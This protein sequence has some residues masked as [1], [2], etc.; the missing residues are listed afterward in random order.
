MSAAYVVLAHKHP[1]QVARLATRLAPAPVFLHVDAAVDPAAFAAVAPGNVVL[2]P[3]HRSGWASWGIVAAILGGMAAAA[4]APGWTHLMVLSGQDYPLCPSAAT[5]AFLARHQDRSFVAR[6]PLPSRLWGR[7][8]GMHRVRYRHWALRG[9][10]AFLP[11][12]RSMPARIAPWGGS[13]YVC[14]ARRAVED[15]LELIERRPDV[16]RFYRRTWIPDEMFLQTAVMNSRAAHGVLNES[17]S[18]IRW[19]DRGGRHPDVL[20]ADDLPALAQASRGPSDVGGHGR[21]KLFARK[22]DAAADAEI[23]DLI[24]ERLLAVG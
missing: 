19:S 21:R 10:R 3:G 18:F 11:V 2:L 13:M 6:W 17:L 24:D 23:L 15:V 7:D 9:R 22:L 16:V 12:P 1:R 4:E 5:A 14:L 8:G 20:R